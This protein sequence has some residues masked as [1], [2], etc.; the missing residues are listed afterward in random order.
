[1]EGLSQFDA[2]EL[3]FPESPVPVREET[4][5]LRVRRSTVVSEE[6]VENAEL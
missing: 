3:Y 6:S 1:M 2:N 4:F 5:V